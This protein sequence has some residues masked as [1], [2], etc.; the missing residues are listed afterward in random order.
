M[1]SHV[2]NTVIIKKITRRACIVQPDYPPNRLMVGDIIEHYDILF[3][4]T[5]IEYVNNDWFFVGDKITK[6][7]FVG[8]KTGSWS[9]NYGRV[10]W[11]IKNIK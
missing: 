2:G 1:K 8:K 9:Q 10:K 4:L 11:S 5:F 3:M 7:G 6:D